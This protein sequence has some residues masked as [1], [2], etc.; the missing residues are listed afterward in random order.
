MDER[1]KGGGG[2]IC[3]RMKGGSRQ[4]LQKKGGRGQKEKKGKMNF[5]REER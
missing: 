5:V 4:I 2:P 1:R 3:E